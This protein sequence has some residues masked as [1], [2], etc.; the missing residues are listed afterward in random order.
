MPLNS[1]NAAI[2]EAV[3]PEIKSPDYLGHKPKNNAEVVRIGRK[4]I[5]LVGLCLS[6]IAGVMTYTVV[7]KSIAAQRLAEEESKGEL[8]TNTIPIL[9]KKPARDSSS[10]SEAPKKMRSRKMCAICEP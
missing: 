10:D 6:V 1:G 8:A 2:N 5:I 7:M 3:N 4:P 9:E